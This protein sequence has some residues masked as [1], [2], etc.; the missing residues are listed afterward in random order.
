MF[1]KKL[2]RSNHRMAIGMAAAVTIVLAAP[3]VLAEGE[4][5]MKRVPPESFVGGITLEEHFARQ[6]DL[7]VRLNANQPEAAGERVIRVDLNDQDRADLA[8]PP[9]GLAPLRIGV[10]KP[11]EPRFEIANGKGFDMGAMT[12]TREGFAWAVTVSSP[13]AQAIRVHLTN[14]SLPQNVELYFYSRDGEVDGPYTDRGR[15]GNG[16]FWTRSIASDTGVIQL[17]YSGKATRAA[18]QA[19]SMVISDLG[20]IQGRP[21]PPQQNNVA[22]HDTWPCADNASCL[23]DANC[24]NVSQVSAAKNAVAKYEWIQGQFI[25]TCT[26]GLIADNDPNTQIPYFLTANHCLKASNS[27]AETFFFYTTSSCN[28][29]CPHN[30]LTG[31]SPAASTVGITLKATGSSGDFSLFTLNQAPPSG[32]VFLGWNTSPVA[33]SNGA[34][35][36][37]I[38]NPNFGPQ[39]YSQHSVDTGS[40]TCT[41]IPRG[42]WIYSHDNTGATMGGSSGSPVVNSAGEIVGQL[43]GCCGFNCGNVC[44]SNNNWTIDG[45]LASYFSAVEPFLAPA[46]GCSSNADCASGELC[47]GSVCTAPV[48]SVNSDCNDG[49]ACTIDTCNSGGTCSASCSNTSVSCGPSDGCCPSGC[50][51]SNDPDCGTSCGGNRA[52]CSSNADCC[53]GNCRGGTCRG[54]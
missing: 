52:P 31:G 16:D 32:T 40:P 54:N 21:V 51:S 2:V 24:V 30:R 15:D 17:Q 7:H 34:N 29:T 41:G 8:A 6:T 39:A 35:L 38:S 22:S 33:N 18:Q 26:G 12:Q 5:K 20:H 27:G 11:I 53:S 42:A 37:R 44:D 25:N 45:A 23:V 13:G 50:S 9:A 48:C 19:M 46:A 28:G 10:V 47:C 43:T 3:L 49:N 36:Y 4:T 1:Q 14:F